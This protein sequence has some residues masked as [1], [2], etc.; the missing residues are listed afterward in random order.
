MLNF[1]CGRQSDSMKLSRPDGFPPKTKVSCT[2][3][4]KVQGTVLY[5]FRMPLG[6]MDFFS[7]CIKLTA[8]D[9]LE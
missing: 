3:V 6:S 4:H 8:A 7:S 2:G 5:G 1:V 9:G